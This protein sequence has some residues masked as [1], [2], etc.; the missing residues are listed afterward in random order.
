M[1][2]FSS[3]LLPAPSTYRLEDGG[4]CTARSKC[5]VESVW[6]SSTTTNRWDSS[7]TIAVQMAWSSN[8]RSN[9]HEM[10]NFEDLGL[11][12]CW[13]WI[14]KSGASIRIGWVWKSLWSTWIIWI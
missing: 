2:D 13:Q 1:L 4:E 14:I 5:T 7:S 6:G 3:V 12:E 11:A 9:R 10:S 8:V